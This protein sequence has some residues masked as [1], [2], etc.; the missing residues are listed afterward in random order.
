[1]QNTDFKLD[2]IAQK[3]SQIVDLVFEIL[4]NSGKENIIN[5]IKDQLT[6]IQNQK[7]LKIAFIGQFNAGKSTI[8]RG[9]T[10]NSTIKISSNVETD[11]STD[12]EWNNI[13]VTDTPGL[14]AGK[15]VEHDQIAKKSITESDL[16]VYVIT[17]Q[18]FDNVILNNFIDIAFKQHYKDKIFVVLN[19]MSMEKGNYEILK[20][21][22]LE[23]I[24]QSFLP[25]YIYDFN[26]VFIDAADYIDGIKDSEP[27]LI[28]L[29]HFNE[30]IFVLNQ[31]VQ[32]KGLISKKFDTP[33]RFI[34]SQLDTL[35]FE[36]VDPLFSSLLNKVENRIF[37]NLKNSKTEIDLLSNQLR[38]KLINKGN[39]FVGKIGEVKI[40]MEREQIEIEKYIQEESNKVSKQIQL[41]LE[42]SCKI[43]SQDIQDVFDSDIAQYFFEGIDGKDIH[44]QNAKTK[45]DKAF[46]E[47]FNYLNK[48]SNQITGKILENTIKETATST[49]L[50]A[51]NVAG[52]NM[53][54]IVYEVGKFFGANFQPYGAV[55][56]AQK[57]G[58]V[59]QA[60]GPILSVISI[61]LTAKQMATEHENQKKLVSAK[62]QSYTEFISIANDIEIQIENQ[63]ENY[64]KMVINPILEDIQKKRQEF[65]ESSKKNSTSQMQIDAAKKQLNELIIE[66]HNS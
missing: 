41:K 64:K 46:R 22:Y 6:S 62:E 17:S 18:L 29:S 24:K 43:L 19:K 12:Y 9:L 28:E 47:K 61:F 10:G 23:S 57:I 50:N 66:I 11:T 45:D 49:M 60:V 21:N 54:T 1:M 27:D 59:A 26:T 3:F 56:I 35:I 53:H 16:L 63:F 15:K 52:S 14:L 40:D 5:T 39:E 13:L 7:L 65:I 36:Q 25:N 30:F 32:K 31:F 2:I 33:L 38:F 20:G 58:N 42:E 8:I 44:L 37:K 4:K 34:L 51:K 48:I 55:H